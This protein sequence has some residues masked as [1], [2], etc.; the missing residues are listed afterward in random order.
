MKR[1]VLV[2]DLDLP[3]PWI[4]ALKDNGIR[5]AP[6]LALA[7]PSSIARILGASLASAREVVREAARRLG[8]ERQWVE[9]VE[10]H[11]EK[12]TTCSLNLDRLLNGGIEVGWVTELYGPFASGKTQLCHQLCVNAQLGKKQGGLGS[13]AAYIDTEGS[14]RPERAREMAE[15]LGLDL[16]EA[17]RNIVVFR[18]SSVK[19]QMA[20]V[21][22]LKQMAKKVRLV[23]VDTVINLF[24]AEYSEE[25]I[26]RQWRLL[27]HLRQLQ[28][29]A[30]LG[31]AVVVANHVVT[32]PSGVE[33]PAGGVVLDAG[34]VKIKLSRHRGLWRA[35]LEAS[36]YLPEGE[37]LFRISREGVRDP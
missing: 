36:P 5:L 11:G 33:V 34:I 35:E 37:A 30:E 28:E 31:V 19:E 25:V 7:Q 12:V 3:A 1:P 17:L 20:A 29:L 23:A 2:E 8:L 22:E 6:Q 26:E 4:E 14:F 24:R 10:A 32:E 27:L 21:S 18:P 16:A 13:K 9:E 15:A